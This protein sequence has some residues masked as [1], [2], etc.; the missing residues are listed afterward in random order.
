FLT[1]NYCEVPGFMQY[2]AGI[3]KPGLINEQ[4]TLFDH[5]AVQESARAKHG[6]R[7]LQSDAGEKSRHLR[8]EGVAISGIGESRGSQERHTI[9]GY[10]S[11]LFG[12]PPLRC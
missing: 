10:S 1:R 7:S 4:H 6:R 2:V 5:Q 3:G 11:P 9:S 8:C 12:E